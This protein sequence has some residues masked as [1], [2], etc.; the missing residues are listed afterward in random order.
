[1]DAS[2]MD[3]VLDEGVLTEHK[4]KAIACAQGFFNGEQVSTLLKIFP[5][6][7]AQLKALHILQQKMYALNTS[8]ATSIMNCFTFSKNKLQALEI[9]AVAIR[10]P[11][12]AVSLEKQFQAFYDEQKRCRAILEQASRLGCRAPMQSYGNNHGN[13]YPIGR[14]SYSNG[15]FTR[16]AL[17]KDADNPYSGIKGIVASVLG[18]GKAAPITYNPCRPTPYPIPAPI[19]HA[20]FAPSYPE[21][22]GAS[23][24]DELK[25]PATPSKAKSSA[26]SAHCTNIK[27]E[28]DSQ[29]SVIKSSSSQSGGMQWSSSQKVLTHSTRSSSSTSRSVTSMK[30]KALDDSCR[31]QALFGYPQP[32]HISPA[33]SSNRASKSLCS[34]LLASDIAQLGCTPYDQQTKLC[35]PLKTEHTSVPPPRPM[36]EPSR[37][38]TMPASYGSAQAH[39]H[40]DNRHTN[41][42]GEL[43]KMYK[44]PPPS[45]HANTHVIKSSSKPPSYPSNFS[46]DYALHI[47]QS[48]SDRSNITPD[49]TSA[50]AK[51]Q[52]LPASHHPPQSS[53]AFSTPSNTTSVSPTL[54]SCSDAFTSQSYTYKSSG[55]FASPSSSTST[56]LPYSERQLSHLAR[57]VEQTPHGCPSQEMTSSNYSR[58]AQPSPTPAHLSESRP[59]A[60]V[61]PSPSPVAGA[62]SKDIGFGPQASMAM[63]QAAAAFESNP[64]STCESQVEQTR[65]MHPN[66]KE[67]SSNGGALCQNY[68]SQEKGGTVL[69]RSSHSSTAGS[70]FS[71][72]MTVP[73]PSR[74]QHSL[75]SRYGLP[76]C[77]SGPALPVPYQANQAGISAFNNAACPPVMLQPGLSLSSLQAD[78]LA[79]YH[80]SAA[81][82]GQS[83]RLNVAFPTQPGLISGLSQPGLPAAFPASA[84]AFLV[85]SGL[86]PAFQTQPAAPGSQQALGTP[87]P[88]PSIFPGVP[89]G[90]GSPSP[91]FQA[92][93]GALSTPVLPD[94]ASIAIGNP[95]SLT[96]SL[97]LAYANQSGLVPTSIF[98]AGGQPTYPGALGWQ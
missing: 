71:E 23:T 7:D 24:K 31:A 18:P 6:A 42:L 48:Y 43:T 86:S 55:I 51:A 33:K 68:T 90:H 65:T 53:V 67:S 83:G 50:V 27:Q 36:S 46:G 10:N 54:S 29:P 37:P 34:A 57:N 30:N 13:P 11:L 20:T 63:I 35:T 89:Q 72:S 22:T 28:N 47:L 93:A 17:P 15:L 69:S 4:L 41:A 2:R 14:P 8:S 25:S 3:M 52:Q 92:S 5:S 74:P 88:V 77:H 45:Y 82:Q 58:Q 62:L 95:L 84:S 80:M 49:P 21:P 12:K 87:F 59:K 96:P 32:S 97:G 16:D 73:S 91:A 70:S 94:A 98:S 85:P 61:A 79:P 78:P 56:T 44:T 26:P 64:M 76:T 81:F 40:P 66:W 60:V 38:N 39:P 19:V 1:M 75:A 9:I